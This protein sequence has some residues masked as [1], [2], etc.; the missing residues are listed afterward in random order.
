PFSL[1]QRESG[2]TPPEKG[3]D[4]FASGPR[5]P[6]WEEDTPVAARSGGLYTAPVTPSD[7]LHDPA[8]SGEAGPRVGAPG[9][10]A[11]TRAN[12]A[13]RALTAAISMTSARSA[14]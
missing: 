12:Y 3:P 10:C 13:T 2:F 1:R 8:L 14:A 9:S 7:I 11:Q 4:D 5:S 6:L